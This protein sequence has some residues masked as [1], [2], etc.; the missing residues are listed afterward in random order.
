MENVSAASYVRMVQYLIEKC[1]V[2]NMNEQECVAALSKHANIQP[3][4]VATIWKELKKENKDFFKSYLRKMEDMRI[5]DE[6]D[7]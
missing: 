4:I 7:E 2:Y 1:L 6:D 5:V 3:V